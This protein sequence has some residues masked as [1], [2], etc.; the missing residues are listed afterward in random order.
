MAGD[1]KIQ[2]GST[3]VPAGG[4]TVAI[5]A[6]GSLDNAFVLLTSN[7]QMGGGDDAYASNLEVDDVSVLAY[8]S[9]TDEITFEHP[10]GSRACK[11]YWEVWE[12]TGTAGGPNEFIVRDR[13]RVAI[14]S[15]ADVT[16]TLANT[17]D[18]I[19]KVIPFIT[20][21]TSSITSNGGR[22]ATCRAWC[23]STA[24]LNVSR[25]GTSGTT[26]VGV[27]SVEFTGSAWIVAHGTVTGQ[28]ADSGS[29]TLKAGS[30]GVAGDTIDLDDWAT[31]VIASWGHAGD[32]T[33]DAIAD[34]WPRLEP[35]SDT[36]TVDY[37]FDAQHDGTDDDITVHVLRHDNLN[38]TRFE[39]TGNTQDGTNVDV[40]SAGLSDL[41][42]SSVLGTAIS[43]G[44]GTAYGRGWRIYRLTSL[45]NVEHWCHRSGN[46]MSHRI[47]VID[48]SGVG[49]YNDPGLNIK[50]G[51]VTA[52]V[53]V[54]SC[55]ATLLENPILEVAGASVDVEIES[56]GQ[57]WIDGT[58]AV[59]SHTLTLPA[60]AHK[61][62][63]I[64]VVKVAV[65]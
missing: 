37:T 56:K 34:H 36:S 63:D 33:N 26:T 44:G 12:Y 6:V 40:T 27:A 42:E 45:T 10:T 54:N 11:V 24:T 52:T 29:I 2:R 39:N 50:I 61:W 5:T 64:E 8:L 19:D 46:T 48:W 49:E 18:S 43:S 62:T 3:D 7:R 53:H 65:T 47:Q 1:I 38:V 20:G 60:G 55:R 30:D 32:N 21:I 41:A 28:T 57:A 22:N 4:T 31:A 14:S 17:P 23:S 51:S 16:A 13:R 9:A 58:Y 25:G 35:G 59:G 15:G